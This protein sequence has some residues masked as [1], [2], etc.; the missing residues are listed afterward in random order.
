MVNWYSVCRVISYGFGICMVYGM[1]LEA[2]T[3]EELRSHEMPAS[4]IY[5]FIF[6]FAITSLPPLTFT[7]RFFLPNPEIL[8]R[9]SYVNQVL[10][11]ATLYLVTTGVQS[12]PLLF[13][14]QLRYFPLCSLRFLIATFVT[15]LY[16]FTATPQGVRIIYNN[17]GAVSVFFILVIWILQQ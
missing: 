14:L 9:A 11:I 13:P 6:S 17:V 1:F 4:V 5:R 15:Q 7:I 8:T 12:L 3:A 2:A 16:L 10:Y